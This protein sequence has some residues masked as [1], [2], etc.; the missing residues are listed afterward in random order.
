MRS[1]KY[2]RFSTQR[3]RSHKI[4][5]TIIP[6]K[7]RTTA[8]LTTQ[9]AERL[10]SVKYD[11]H[12]EIEFFREFKTSRCSTV[13]CEKLAVFPTKLISPTFPSVRQVDYTSPCAWF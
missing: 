8:I 2:V 10:S 13:D 7:T 9:R 5:Y 6:Y 3:H 11:K 1:P 12:W 4:P